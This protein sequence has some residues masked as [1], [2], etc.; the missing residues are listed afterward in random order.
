MAE[1]GRARLMRAGLAN[2]T[3]AD[4]VRLETL[5]IPMRMPIGL[6]FLN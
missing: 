4:Y 6:R 2:W 5:P 1:T 3:R